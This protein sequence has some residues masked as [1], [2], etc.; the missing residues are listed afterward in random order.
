ME[1]VQNI[2]FSKNATAVIILSKEFL[3]IPLNEKIP[4]I[5][6]LEKKTKLVRG[7]IQHAINILKNVGAITL[8]SRGR[9]GTFLIDKDVAGLLKLS[10]ITV[11]MG[12]MPLPYSKRYE[13]L[14]TG[15]L[16]STENQ[17]NIPSTMS[18]MRGAKNRI[19]M[20]LMNRYDYAIVSK[21]AA[22][23]FLE[24]NPG[25]IKIVKDFGKYSYLSN[26][27]ILFSNYNDYEIKD[28]M[29]IGIDNSSIDHR[30]LT[31]KLCNKHNVIYVE[32]DYNKV[33]SKILNKEIDA[34]IWN[35]DEIYDKYI[36]VNYRVVTNNDEYDTIAVLVVNAEKTELISLLNEI[37]D[38]N[39]VLQNQKLVLEGKIIPSY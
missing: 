31:Y 37:I 33:L 32:T 11:I 10:G 18:Y 36:N 1:K 17:Y 35:K 29:K 4:T 25:S 14:A 27:I 28:G 9:N 5:T 12:C 39:V 22:E 6:D 26:H 20:L 30:E 38:K 21:M 13:G 8:K 19:G 34:A 7:T 15:L 2:L 24:E 23:L 3:I 16:V